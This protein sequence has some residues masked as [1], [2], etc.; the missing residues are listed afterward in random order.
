[1]KYKNIK[2]LKASAMGFGCWAIGGT[3]NNV[4]EEQSIRTIK[5]A[6]NV[7]INFFDIAP[8]YGFGNAEKVL[9]KAIQSEQRDKIIIATKCGLLW[10]DNDL[11]KKPQNNLSAQSIIKEVEDSLSRLGTDYVDLYQVHWPD[12]TTPIEETALALLELKKSGKIRHIG[13]SNYSLDM[14]REMQQY[15]EIATFQGLYNLLEQNPRHYHNIPLE[16]RARDEALPFCHQHDI[17]YL[18]YSPLMQGLLIGSLKREGNWDSNDSRAANPKLNGIGFEPYFNCVEELKVLA[19]EANIPLAHLALHW[20]VG[21]QE[22]GSII[23]GAHTEQQVK[24][25]ADFLNSPCSKEILSQAE[26]IVKKWN[27]E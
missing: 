24:D 6:I 22:I 7:G 27:L 10:D 18:P 1:M 9:G 20:L 13:V 11:S 17:K 2:D 16:Y 4:T 25:N 5:E 12:P 8:I 19:N 26:A 3:W 23:A 15:V 14:T 21:Q